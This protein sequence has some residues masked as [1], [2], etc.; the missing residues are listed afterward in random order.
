MVASESPQRE[1][2][3][4]ATSGVRHALARPVKVTEDSHFEL[5]LRAHKSTPSMR[6]IRACKLRDI[7]DDILPGLGKSENPQK[8]KTDKLEN[9]IGASQAVRNMKRIQLFAPTENPSISSTLHVDASKRLNLAQNP[10]VFGPPSGRRD[11][12]AVRYDLHGVRDNGPVDGRPDA[13]KKD[14]AAV[15]EIIDVR[16]LMEYAPLLSGEGDTTIDNILYAASPVPDKDGCARIVVQ[17]SNNAAYGGKYARGVSAQR[18]SRNA[19]TPHPG[20]AAAA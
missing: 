5:L 15:E 19:K 18:H 2:D 1:G 4:T 11:I 10:D 6:Y 13:P 8:L 16:L 9:S 17:Y 14:S 20:E 7:P 12:Y 3:E